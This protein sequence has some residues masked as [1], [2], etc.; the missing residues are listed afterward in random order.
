MTNILYLIPFLRRVEQ[1]AELYR[2][3]FFFFFALLNG[4]A[5]VYL[6][7]ER[8]NLALCL[9]QTVKCYDQ[10]TLIFS[11]RGSNSSFHGNSWKCPVRGTTCGHSTGDTVSSYFHC[12]LLYFCTCRSFSP[13]RD[14]Q[15][16]LLLSN[17]NLHG[18]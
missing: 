1:H 14:A 10:S 17:S 16:N 15:Q 9:Q 4:H 6:S 11:S 18:N 3:L 5:V 12:V 2:G 8:L 13:S 7:D